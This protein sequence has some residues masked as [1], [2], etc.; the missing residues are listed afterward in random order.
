MQRLLLDFRQVPATPEA[1]EAAKKRGGDRALGIDARPF[2]GMEFLL[3]RSHREAGLE[4]E[5]E[6]AVGENQIFVG[7]VSHP[8]LGKDLY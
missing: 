8:D 6:E 5:E 3:L 7:S 1:R 2:Y 4:D